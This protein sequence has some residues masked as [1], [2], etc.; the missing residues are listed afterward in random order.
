[1][2]GVYVF[3]LAPSAPNQVIG[4][5]SQNGETHIETLHFLRGDRSYYVIGIE[6]AS[7]F[8]MYDAAAIRAMLKQSKGD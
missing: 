5:Q 8:A 1:M 3:E 2:N 7:G 6:D 4:Q